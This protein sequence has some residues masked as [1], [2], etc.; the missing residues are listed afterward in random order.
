MVKI[1]LR[2]NGSVKT[3]L[4]LRISFTWHLDIGSFRVNKHS[5]HLT[6]SR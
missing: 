2:A 5:T 4:T 6:E 1:V 3:L